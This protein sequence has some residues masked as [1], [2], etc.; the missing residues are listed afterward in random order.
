MKRLIVVCE[1][2]TEKEFCNDL[3]ADYF[4]KKGIV[5]ESPLIKHSGGGIVPWSTLK[6][7]L[8]NHL[9]EDN[10]YVTTFIDYYGIKDDYG[11]PGWKEGKRIAS[12]EGRMAFLEEQM[13]KDMEEN[14]RSRFIPHLQL[15]EFETLLFS[16]IEA[17]RKNFMPNE[18]KWNE[19]ESIVGEFPNPE[20]INNSPQKAPSKRLESAIQG[21]SKV[22]YGNCVAMDIGID[23]MLASCPHFS[24]WINRLC[25]I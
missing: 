8:R 11:Y 7:Q 15:H 13:L 18:V 5:V 6:N 17:K 9:R 19:L 16:D 12:K 10:A 14:E 25:E 3:L 24:K 22:L 1:G 21:Y 4:F 2:P 23:K 20:D